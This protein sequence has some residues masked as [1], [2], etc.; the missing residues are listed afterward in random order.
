MLVD[1]VLGR[2]ASRKVVPSGW[3][4]EIS[5]VYP[6]AGAGFLVA[7]TADALTMPGLP[8]D[9][10]AAGMDIDEDGNISGLF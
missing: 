5:Q 8:A 10:A 2:D 6:S 3:K 4:L 9:P 1:D 7:L